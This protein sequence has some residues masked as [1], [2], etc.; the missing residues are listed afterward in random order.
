MQKM[1]IAE[2]NRQ[3][4]ERKIEKESKKKRGDREC[5]SGWGCGVGGDVV[6]PSGSRRCMFI[7]VGA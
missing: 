4:R 6:V 1:G 2:I 7:E 3:R 5:R